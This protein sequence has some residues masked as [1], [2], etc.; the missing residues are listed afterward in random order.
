MRDIVTFNQVA[1][2]PLSPVGIAANAL[3]SSQRD[4]LMRVIDVYTGAAIGQRRAGG[5]AGHRIESREGAR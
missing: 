2:S 1:A 4:L 3:T 5:V